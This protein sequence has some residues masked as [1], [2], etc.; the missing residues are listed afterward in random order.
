MNRLDTTRN[1][2]LSLKREEREEKHRKDKK[3]LELTPI[4]RDEVAQNKMGTLDLYY[5]NL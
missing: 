5:V 3:P 4:Y 2:A 1:C